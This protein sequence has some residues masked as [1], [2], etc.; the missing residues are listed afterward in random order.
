MDGKVADRLDLESA[1]KGSVMSA[2]GLG[3]FPGKGEGDIGPIEYS[4]SSSLVVGL[5]W[6]ERNDS[7][8]HSYHT[9]FSFVSRQIET[10]SSEPLG[11]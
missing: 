7:A 1:R 2:I 6:T 11:R 5:L 4:K 3:R 9:C 8:C 10:W